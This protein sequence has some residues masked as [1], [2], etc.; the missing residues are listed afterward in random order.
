MNHG[1][2]LGLIM[3]HGIIIGIQRKFENT[4]IE[5]TQKP[6]LKLPLGLKSSQSLFLCSEDYYQSIKS[7]DIG[8]PYFYFC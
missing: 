2:M 1:I 6:S 4:L 5:R 7:L 3:N 8:Y